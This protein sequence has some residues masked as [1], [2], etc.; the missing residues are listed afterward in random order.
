M[1]CII[2]QNKWLAWVVTEDITEHSVI[3][4]SNMRQC[5]AVEENWIPYLRRNVQNR[6]G[7]KRH[8]SPFSGGIAREEGFRHVQGGG[9]CSWAGNFK[10]RLCYLDDGVIKAYSIFSGNQVGY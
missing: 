9:L 1:F 2:N 7:I 3:A 8:T 6:D 5:Y 4:G 10:L